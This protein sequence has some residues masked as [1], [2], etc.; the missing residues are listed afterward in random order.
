MI[1][2][3]AILIVTAAVCYLTG[4][5]TG[6][7]R[8]SWIAGV[9]GTA[10]A[11]L[12][13]LQQEG[14]Q[15]TNGAIAWPN[16][17][18]SWGTQLYRSDPLAASL[19]EWCILLGGLCLLRLGDDENA[20]GRQAA[21]VLTIATLYSLVY[22]DD[23]RLFAGE[24]LLLVLL[25]WAMTWGETR[26]GALASR[27][28]VAQTL[29]ALALLGSVLLMGRTTGGAY[30]LQN[31]S[32]SALTVWPLLLIILFVLCWVG[33]V[34]LTGWS[35]LLNRER[36]AGTRGTL[37]QG[38]ILGVPA[39]VLLLRLQA[40]ITSQAPAGSV[41]ADWSWFTGGLSWL[42]G[43]TTV[44]ASA[45]CI[46]WAG[47]SRWSA[48]LTAFVLGTT[49]WA[50]GL[51]TPAGR[52]AALACLLAYGLGHL[53]LDMSSGQYE[54][55]SRVGAG[56]SLVGA[57]ATVGFVGLWLLSTALAGSQHPAIVVAI[58]G[59][60]I[61]AACGAALHLAAEERERIP[62]SAANRPNLMGWLAMGLCVL[63]VAGGALPGLWLPQVVKMAA[64]AGTG[65]RIATGWAGVV[66]EGIFA[67]LPLLAG[68]ALLIGGLGWL[69]RAWA[70]S[71]AA[72]NS[73]LLPTAVA[74]LQRV[75]EDAPPVQPLISNPPPAVWWLSV[76]WLE[77]GL[78]GFGAVLNRLATRFGALLARLEGRFYFP[79]ALVLTLL[80]LLAI[81]R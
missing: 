59:A 17:F 6:S 35:S 80:V 42:G 29:G 48:A 67:P 72:G 69:V 44:A 71:S 18:G 54:W 77:G 37:V 5:S 53:A 24:V 70:K 12:L 79:L 14:L 40:L 60:A 28:R 49:T 74:R 3:L 32:L 73:V 57:P 52:Y 20:S 21:A 16:F 51:D 65:S 45:S 27:Q 43:I 64:I 8:V 9:V 46:V 30:G 76:A 58:V 63:L 39:V 66:S 55:L 38:L 23:L 22:T 7:R 4:L 31:M 11:L 2:V 68:G 50:L 10:V 33:L 61:M 13:A 41:P 25:T 26:S 47:T 78:F 75:R 56:L 62:T 19:G 81:T 1:Y 15:G 36:V 34:P